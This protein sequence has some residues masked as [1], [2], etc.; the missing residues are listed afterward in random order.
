MGM[1]GC[2]SVVFHTNIPSHLLSRVVLV[3]VRLQLILKTSLCSVKTEMNYVFE[4]LVS[5]KTNNLVDLKPN[6][7]DQ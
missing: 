7:T 1:Q 3:M 2:P 6:E 5:T 4:K